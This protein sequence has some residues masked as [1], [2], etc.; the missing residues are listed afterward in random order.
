MTGPMPADLERERARLTALAP[1]FSSDEGFN[2][3]LIDY[4]FD[5]LRPF[6]EGAERCL[7][8]GSADGRM[9][10][11]LAEITSSLVA[12]DGSAA[13]VDAVR[14]RLPEVTAVC[15]LFEEF[16]PDEAPDVVVLAHVLEHVDDP[17]AL[18]ARVR[19]YLDPE[20]RIVIT[21]PNAGSIHRHV[22][23]AM[24]LLGDTTELNDADR[25]IG[26]RRVYTEATLIEDV[27]DAGFEPFHIG[28]V[29]L[30]TLS[31]AQIDE[32]PGE[33]QDAFYEVG[34]LFPRL[35]AEL[36]VVARPRE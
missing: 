35:C 21:V 22:G 12:V 2:A 19:S 25:R 18:L 6:V 24:G 15:A 13:Y 20:G 9:T 33:L 1:D 3:R 7:E 16:A 26:H 10:A 4:R 28:G 29:F 8:L 30:K 11:L 36:L 32:W 14:R 17:A 27:V 31:N 5:S 34:R 23:V